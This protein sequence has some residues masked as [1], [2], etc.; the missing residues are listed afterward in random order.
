MVKY[1]ILINIGLALGLGLRI[2]AYLVSLRLPVSRDAT[3]LSVGDLTRALETGNNVADRWEQIDTPYVECDLI[4]PSNPVAIIQMNIHEIP[5]LDGL[6]PLDSLTKP[7][8][9]G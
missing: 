5:H 2:Y 9:G 4:W 3:L 1:N 7:F 6:W 8:I